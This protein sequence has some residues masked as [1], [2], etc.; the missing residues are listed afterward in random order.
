VR[1]KAAVSGAVA[2]RCSRFE[3]ESFVI[4]AAFGENSFLAGPPMNLHR[5]S[6][7]SQRRV[8]LRVA[9]F[10]ATVKTSRNSLANVA[11]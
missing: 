8:V 2:R 7:R 1:D 4:F 9:A 3:N 10:P 5:R 11:I 6:Q